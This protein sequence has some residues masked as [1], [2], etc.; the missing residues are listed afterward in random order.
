MELVDLAIDSV[1]GF[2]LNEG[3]TVVRN[4][5]MVVLPAKNASAWMHPLF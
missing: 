2:F 3:V 5:R 4:V 1:E